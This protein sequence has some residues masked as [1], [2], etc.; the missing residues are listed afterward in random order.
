MASEAAAGN[1]GVISRDDLQKVVKKALHRAIHID[2][3]SYAQLASD[4]GLSARAIEAYHLEG[5]LPPAPERLLSLMF[6]M[7]EPGVNAV[8][9]LIGYACKPIGA[10]EEEQPMQ[11]VASMMSELAT[12]GTAS[13]DGRIDHVEAPACDRAAA[14]IIAAA[15]KFRKSA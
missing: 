13:A 3:V 12:L 7:G 6:A 2:K 4:S 1:E 10:A 15:A 5:K 9:S 11:I 14:N 8:L